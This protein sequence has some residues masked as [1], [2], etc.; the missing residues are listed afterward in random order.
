MLQVTLA[1]H[2]AK[3]GDII[4]SNESWK[5]VMDRCE[6]LMLSSGDVKLLRVNSPIPVRPIPPIKLDPNIASALET[7]IPSAILSK[8]V[9][10]REGQG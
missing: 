4:L 3:P 8:M 5:M 9:C 1:E 10:M 6:G 2:Q 7:Y